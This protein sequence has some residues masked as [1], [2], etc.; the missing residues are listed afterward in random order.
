MKEPIKALI[1]DDDNYACE[2]LKILLQANCPQLFVAGF[3][4]TIDEAVKQINLLNPQVIFL[5]MHL[6]KEEGFDLFSKID[7]SKC[8]IIVVSAFDEFALKAFKFNTID[9]LLKPIDIDL[10]KQAVDRVFTEIDAENTKN[11]LDTLVKGFANHNALR[12]FGSLS[13]ITI[14]TVF[15]SAFID[16]NEIIHCQADRNYTHLF[17]L[18]GKKFISSK[19][20][21]QIQKLLPDSVFFRIHHSHIIN[22]NQMLEYHKGKQAYVLMKTEI[23]LPI[24]QN[25]KTDFLKRLGV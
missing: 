9:Y 3:A 20:L 2:N 11:N 15:G 4:L 14:P 7:L 24:S 25:K 13:T 10:L 16:Y 18:N 6:G 1:I 17:L 23:S 22:L 12:D 8:K 21:N 19:S 5:D